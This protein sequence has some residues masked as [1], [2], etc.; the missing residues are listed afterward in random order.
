MGEGHGLDVGMVEGRS[1]RVLE[2]TGRLRAMGSHGGFQAE[3]WRA[4]I[5]RKQGQC[6]GDH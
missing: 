1:I 5:I 2:G 3:E 4:C 6:H